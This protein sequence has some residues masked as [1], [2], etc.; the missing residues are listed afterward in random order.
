MKLI[1]WLICFL[2]LW[3]ILKFVVLVFKRLG[4]KTSLNRLIDKGEDK[5]KDG[6]D[7][8]ADW[9]RSGKREKEKEE[10]YEKPEVT[11]H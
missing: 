10:D 7:R 6:A 1:W 11:I 8:F 4:S 3:T 5:M 2:T 9:V